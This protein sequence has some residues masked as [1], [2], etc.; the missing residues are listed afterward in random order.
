MKLYYGKPNLDG[1]TFSKNIL[2]DLKKQ[3]GFFFKPKPLY[4]LYNAKDFPD[5]ESI[6]A[7]IK[8]SDGKDVICIIEEELDKRSCFY[9]TFSKQ[10]I[11]KKQNKI[12]LD[13]KVQ[14]FY[15]NIN[16]IKNILPSESVSFLYKLFYDFRHKEYKQIAGKCINLVLTGE[17]KTEYILKIFI[18][19]CLDKQR[20]LG[21]NK[22]VGRGAQ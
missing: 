18:L 10:I 7:L 11:G 19:G 4:F 6:E 13:D 14:D 9:K 21:Y 2:N 3:Y 17:V 16:N 22:K 8:L 12:T 15:K 1:Y 5:K 20:K